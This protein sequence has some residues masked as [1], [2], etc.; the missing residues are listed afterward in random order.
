[1]VPGLSRDSVCHGGGQQEPKAAGYMASSA[2]KQRGVGASAEP[3]LSF[4][5]FYYTCGPSLWGQDES[6]FL[7]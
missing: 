1:M 7:S 6:A 2:R 5:L 4:S 3:A